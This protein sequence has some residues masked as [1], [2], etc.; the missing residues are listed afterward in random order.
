MKTGYTHIAVVLDRSGS[1]SSCADDTK[2]GFD[3]FIAEQKKVAG[4][5]T[6][7]LAQFDDVY[8]VVHDAKD[9]QSVPPLVFMPRGSTALLDAIGKTIA[10]TGERLAA[11]R[12]DDRPEHVIFVILTDGHENASKE[13]KR[14]KIMEMI[15]HQQEAYKW[16]F[17]FLGANQDAIQAG[18]SIGINRAMSMT[19]DQHNTRQ[20]Y[21]TVS[22]NL[23]AV[24]TGAAAS[25]SFTDKDRLKN[26]PK[27]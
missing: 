18:G 17:V 14:E 23:C 1:M 8:E 5:A 7:T 24:R 6:L 10:A 3:M 16:Q 26:A 11:Q 2:G 21:S 22:S 13:F 27:A 4:T 20:A 19:Y 9:I 12:E 15:K 25:M